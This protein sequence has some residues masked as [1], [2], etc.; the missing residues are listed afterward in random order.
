MKANQVA[1]RRRNPRGRKMSR[2]KKIGLGLL[3]VGAVG[4]AAALVVMRRRGGRRQIPSCG[5]GPGG[6]PM[7]WNAETERCE[8][9]GGQSQGA[10][11]GN[12]LARAKRRLCINPT[13]LTLEQM[14][15][16][17]EGVFLPLIEAAPDPNSAATP[18]IVA[19][20]ALQ[21]LCP[22]MRRQAV[23]NVVNQL[24][25]QAWQNY[26]GFAG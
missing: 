1:V 15:L 3:A 18:G 11:T 10:P 2:N 24:A 17:Q 16:L 13:V 14:L 7:I 19:E 9:V 5:P 21:Q 23:V 12:P 22:G 26:T 8:P 4:G 6:Q 20:Q 25:D